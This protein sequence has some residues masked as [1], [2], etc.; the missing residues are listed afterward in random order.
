M[1]NIRRLVTAGLY[2]VLVEGVRA[3]VAKETCVA[4][5]Y[6]EDEY[7]D[8]IR[9]HRDESKMMERE[10]R[11]ERKR[12]EKEER[13]QIMRAPMGRKAQALLSEKRQ[14]N[15]K[16]EVGKRKGHQVTQSEFT[17][18]IKAS[19]AYS[20]YGKLQIAPF[21]VDRR[22]TRRM[23]IAIRGGKPNEAMGRD[24]IHIE[25][26]QADIERSAELLTP[27]WE[28]VGRTEEFPEEWEEGLRCPLYK[29]GPQHD[30]ANYRPVCLMSNA[31]KTVDTAVLLEVNEKL[32]PAKSQ[33]GFQ[34]GVSET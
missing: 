1:E 32:S 22:M 3:H 6:Q 24:G 31:R 27:W 14:R 30:T 11:K 21:S 34:C 19:H 28:T 15:M 18:Q 8:D 26:L 9:E 17:R 29:S 13:E 10:D 4:P 20:E 2:M 7:M 5:T 23:E 25:M 12:M 33:C 16:E